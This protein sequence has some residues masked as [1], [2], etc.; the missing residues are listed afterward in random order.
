MDL[1]SFDNKF[2]GLYLGADKLSQFLVWG[3]GSLFVLG[4]MNADMEFGTL[5]MFVGYVALL[6]GPME[7]FSNI[8]RWWSSCMNSAQ[9][10]FEII[11]SRP[12]V[13]ERHDPVRIEY[14]RGDIE[15]RNV[16]FEY[17]A[18]KEVL[19]EVNI[20]VG[21]GEMLG[22]EGKSGAGK[23]TLVNLI[24][25]LYDP[26]RGD[27]FIDG[28]NVRDLKMSDIRGNVAMVSQET[29]IF[30]GTVYENIAYA[31][32]ESTRE[33]VISAAIAASAHDFICNMPDGY[34]TL[35]GSG[36]RD[37][38]GGEK[39]R[40]SIARA[41]LVNP[42]IL[43]LDEATAAVDTETEKNIQASLE[44]LIVGRT[45]ISI[46][47]RISTLRNADKLIVMEDGKIVEEGTHLELANK[48]GT[49][50]KLIQIQSKALAM[51]GVGE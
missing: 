19:K 28:I 33:E 35:I 46:A 50:F 40:V 25:R 22:I 21:A 26:K 39:Q 30:R 34:D 36:G 24:S 8:F 1:I 49:Y 51:R 3:F 12:E 31:K 5:I 18:N 27:V 47:H 13:A 44:K 23:S 41:I 10:I 15:L 32:P 17:E 11:D 6:T 14:M 20:K 42:R 4:Y 7:F 29:Y 43:I 45:T 2:T 9:R 16:T 37:L 38:S 48:K